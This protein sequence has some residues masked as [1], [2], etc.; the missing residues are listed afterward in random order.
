MTK[1]LEINVP[2]QKYA[3]GLVPK[4]VK[5]TIH[6]KE[7]RLKFFPCTINPCVIFG[8]PHVSEFLWIRFSIPYCDSDDPVTAEQVTIIIKK[9]LIISPYDDYMK[10]FKSVSFAVGTSWT[11]SGIIRRSK[12]YFGYY[13]AKIYLRHSYKY[14]KIQQS[15]KNV[16]H[17]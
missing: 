5:A 10:K 9:F 11:F 6:G 2:A 14:F 12:I 1:V 8:T 4:C 15:T 3:G 7:P 13:A 16:F 17:C